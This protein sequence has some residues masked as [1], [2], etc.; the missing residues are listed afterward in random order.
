[1]AKQNQVN[2]TMADVKECLE[3]EDFDNLKNE[4]MACKMSE[5]EGWKN[6]VKSVAFEAIKEIKPISSN[7][8]WKMSG[9]DDSQK[10][11]KG[12]WD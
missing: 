12:L 11:P 4:G 3:D 7:G 1:M 6:K 10:E 2:Q 5:I 8:L 9:V